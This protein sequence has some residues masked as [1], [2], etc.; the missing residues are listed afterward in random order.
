MT[1]DPD[2]VEEEP[3]EEEEAPAEEDDEPKLP[4]MKKVRN[5]PGLFFFAMTLSCVCCRVQTSKCQHILFPSQGIILF[6]T[7][8]MLRFLINV[9]MK[10]FPN[11]PW[12][13]VHLGTM[14]AGGASSAWCCNCQ[15]W[16]FTSSLEPFVRCS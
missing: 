12:Y 9:T 4:A 14:F 5:M 13:L 7:M 1:E 2:P 8:A 16:G 3:V 15:G 10:S 11:K 6:L